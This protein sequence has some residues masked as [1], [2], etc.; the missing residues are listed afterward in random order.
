MHESLLSDTSDTA[1]YAPDD[2]SPPPPDAIGQGLVSLVAILLL[3]AL[4][5]ACRR[6]PRGVKKASEV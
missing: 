6:A 3:L 1:I 4:G 2:V 5:E